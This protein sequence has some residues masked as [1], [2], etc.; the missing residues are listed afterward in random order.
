[1]K[2]DFLSHK[3]EYESDIAFINLNPRLKNAFYSCISS[4]SYKEFDLHLTIFDYK[5]EI[6]FLTKNNEDL[7]NKV[8][9][10]ENQCINL[11]NDND[12]L[13]KKIQGMESNDSSKITYLE[14]YCNNLK[15]E[16]ECLLFDNLKLKDSNNYFKNS[17]KK[18]LIKQKNLK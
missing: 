11:R 12:I 3:D 5:N 8:S 9:N 14:N 16:N 1:M 13:S 2:E 17:N 18:L 7:S 6:S 10:F 4:D 15:N